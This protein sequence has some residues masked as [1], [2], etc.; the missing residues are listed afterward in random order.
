VNGK[1]FP[2]WPPEFNQF[3]LFGIILIA[4]LIGGQLAQRTRYLPRIT[5]YIIAG[6]LLGPSITN[7]INAEL[8][9]N[10]RVF[11][12]I[13]LGLILFQ[14][15]ML[16]DVRAVAK[17]RPLLATSL[18]ES[19]LS[20][21]LVFIALLAIEIK[22]IFAALAA[23]A[24]I[25]ASP[26]VVLLVSR[27]LD[28]KGPVTERSLHLVALNNVIAFFAFTLILPTLHAEQQAGI[29]TIIVQPL[30]ALGGSLLIAYLLALA[31][32]RIATLVGK[33]HAM[34]FALMVGM[35]MAALGAAKMFAAS[36]LLTLLALGIITRM[37]DREEHMLGVEFG[38]GGG[39]FFIILFAV[40]GANLHL[41]ELVAAFG[42]AVLFVAVRFLAKGASIYT[43]SRYWA[44]FTTTQS[45]MCGMTMIPMAGLAIGIVNQTTAMYPEFGEQLGS[46]ILAAVAILE[47]IG[48]IA[49][50]F[51]LKRAGEVAA[52]A[53]VEH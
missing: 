49:T 11:V 10:A 18:L 51:A 5:G 47:T 53:K 28:A 9:E 14:L 37:L 45:L 24:G 1:L 27:E 31:T 20:F 22:P 40:S 48:P 3:I 46:I 6:F 2:I 35:I 42:A 15:G 34:Q 29:L 19:L 41:G 12:D 36:T 44:G 52:D 33:S 13:A 32:L 50:E 38:H 21:V 7:I 16:L 4:G 39:I 17:D 30:Y 43:V 23:A 25:S 8:L 26:A